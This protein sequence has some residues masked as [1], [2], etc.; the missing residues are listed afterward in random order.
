[1]M[2]E[3]EWA[4]TQYVPTTDEYMANAHISY[5]LAPIVLPS[6]YFVGQE[7][8]ESVIK[9]QEY[10]ELY[11][12]MSTCGRLLNDIRGLEVFGPLYDKTLYPV[13]F[14]P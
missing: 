1:M 11:R 3:A 9:E 10:N 12:L 8:L 14:F 5:G 13:N 4:R 7:L 2:T 6:L